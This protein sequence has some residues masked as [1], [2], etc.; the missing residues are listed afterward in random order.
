MTT[1]V[2]REPAD[3]EH[4]ARGACDADQGCGVDESFSKSKEQR[5]NG[6]ASAVDGTASAVDSKETARRRRV[7]QIARVL[8]PVGLT[9]AWL[10]ELGGDVVS[11][12]DRGLRREFIGDSMMWDLQT[13][14]TAIGVYPSSRS[15]IQ[16]RW[17]GVA[18]SDERRW[19]E[20]DNA[21][22][23]NWVMLLALSAGA[24]CLFMAKKGKQVVADYIANGVPEQKIKWL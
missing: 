17:A 22:T 11:L 3:F 23:F 14:G 5:K 20:E 15:D 9:L 12:H 24:W 2:E 7:V 19:R 4:D 8:I 1:T 16:S 6:A 18:Q 21:R 10:T 13:G